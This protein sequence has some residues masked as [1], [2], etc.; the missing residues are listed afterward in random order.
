MAAVDIAQLLAFAVKNNAS[1]LHLSAG[2]P[3]IIRVD[4]D[5]GMASRQ[6][7]GGRPVGGNALSG[8]ET[9]SSGQQR[10]AAHRRH[11]ASARCR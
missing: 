2:V 11:P 1:D 3:P 8:A 4:G 5:V 7:V 6:F 10:A 9:G